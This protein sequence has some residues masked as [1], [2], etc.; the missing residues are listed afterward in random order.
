MQRSKQQKV[1]RKSSKDLDK[2]LDDD[3]EAVR[4]RFIEARAEEGA[5]YG[6]AIVSKIIK[7]DVEDD[8]EKR[9]FLG[10]GMMPR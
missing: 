8:Y 9:T 4:T 5:V 3:L 6:G 1:K 2:I 7:R 10:E